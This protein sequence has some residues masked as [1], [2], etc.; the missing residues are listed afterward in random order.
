[1]FSKPNDISPGTLKE[2]NIISSKTSSITLIDLTKISNTASQNII[3]KIDLTKKSNITSCFHLQYKIKEALYN[4]NNFQVKF[5]VLCQQC[6]SDVTT[7][8]AKNELFIALNTLLDDSFRYNILE[9]VMLMLW[10]YPTQILFDQERLDDF[11]KKLESIL[12]T[13]STNISEP[14]LVEGLIWLLKFM[15]QAMANLIPKY[16]LYDTNVESLHKPER[17]LNKEDLD[18]MLNSLR[19]LS[20][21]MNEQDQRKN[22][23]DESNISTD[24][25]LSTNSMIIPA[26]DNNF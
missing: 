24:S 3:K 4:L 20:S 26:T 14:E 7:E 6:V 13:S 10:K 17:L 22:T 12:T 15:P 23:E 9:Q 21:V 2:T 18:I 5:K 11:K 8:N 25:N 16:R 1:M 19:N